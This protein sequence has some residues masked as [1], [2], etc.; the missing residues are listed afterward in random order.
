M[1]FSLPALLALPLAALAAPS[2]SSSD[3]IAARDGCTIHGQWNSNWVEYANSRYRV[4]I[5]HDGGDG[6]LNQ[7]WCDFF[8]SELSLLL[9]TTSLLHSALY[10][11][12]REKRK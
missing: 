1:K 3:V 8:Y 9:Y 7:R 11:K 5:W 6:N 2:S 4:H 10:N 12:P